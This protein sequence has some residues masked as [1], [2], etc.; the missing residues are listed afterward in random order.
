MMRHDH[1]EMRWNMSRVRL[2]V[3]TRKG[4]F[5]L[6][7]DGKREDWEVSVPHCGG[8]VIYH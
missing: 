7:A 1:Y 6:T 8:G 2:L 3:G 5:I 4:A